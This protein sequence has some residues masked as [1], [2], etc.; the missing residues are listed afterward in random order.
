MSELVVS[1]KIQSPQTRRRHK[2]MKWCAVAAV[3]NIPSPVGALIFW[4][5]IAR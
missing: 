2:I 1:Y 4:V 3:L 5:V